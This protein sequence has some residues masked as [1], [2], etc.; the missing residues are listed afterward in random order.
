MKESEEFYKKHNPNYTM[1]FVGSKGK[2]AKE[3][4]ITD[5]IRTYISE[6]TKQE[7]DLFYP[8][9]NFKWRIRIRICI[10]YMSIYLG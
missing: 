7:L 5:E 2:I 8:D 1:D 6:A 10:G 9:I 3:E 4:L